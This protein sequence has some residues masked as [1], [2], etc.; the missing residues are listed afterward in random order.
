MLLKSIDIL[1]FKSF[2]DKTHLEFSRGIT[3]LLGPNGC[4][5]SNILDSVKWALGEQSSRS[6]RADK[7]EDVIFSGT[8]S[9]KALNLA[10]VTLI[11]SNEKEELPLDLTEISIKRRLYRS[12]ESEYFINNTPVRLREIREL[13]FDTGVG[14]SAYSIME[15]GK[16]DQILSSKPEDR[17]FIAEEA[18]GIT[19]YRI[20]EIEAERKLEKTKENMRQV[21]GIIGEV[22]RSW[23]LLKRQA[24]RT[25]NYRVL[26]EQV[27][28]LELE[29]QLLRLKDFLEQ[30]ESTEEKFLG[31]T[32]ERDALRQG[33]EAINKNMELDFDLVNS[34]ESRLIE[35]QKK[36]YKIDLEKHNNESQIKILRERS[37]ELERKI[38]SD[39]ERERG[40]R[41]KLARL[42]EELEGKKRELNELSA[43]LKDVQANIQG[44]ER[45]IKQFEARIHE[46]E[47]EILRL[48]RDTLS[49]EEEIE[50]RRI[51]LRRITDDI[52]T[53][54]DQ[55]LKDLGYST[56]SRKKI[57][58]EILSAVESI[59]IQISGRL[60]LLEDLSRVQE[61]SAKGDEKKILGTTLPVLQEV[62]A[63]I[64]TLGRL[65]TE[66]R[67]VT[68]SFLEEFLA[69]EGIITR[70]REIDRKISA[71]LD[72]INRKRSRT[73]ELQQESRALNAKIIEYRQTLEGLR[74]NRARMNTQK[75]GLDNEVKRLGAEISEQD[76]FLK[77]NA[78]EI[79]LSRQSLKEIAMRIG[80]LTKEKG[81]LEE[82]NR[83]LKRDLSS[84]EDKIA[85]KNKTLISREQQLKG[86][87]AKLEKLQSGLER[88][89]MDLAEC[90]AEIRNLYQN[91]SD[92]HSRDLSEFESRTLRI[93][94]TLKELRAGLLGRKDELKKLGQVNLMAVE[95]FAEVNDRYTF[96]SGQLNDLRKASEDLQKITRE[97]R[98]ESAELFLE[99]Y[100][101][102][103]KNF[104]LM[105]RRL[106][107]GGRAELKLTDPANVLES[108][109]EIFAQPPGK[110]LENIALL[111]GGEKSLTAIGLLFATYMVKPSPFCIL[112]EID[113]ALDEANIV[114]FIQLLREFSTGSQFIVITHNK[115]T[116]AGADTMLGITMEESGVSKIVALRL[117]NK[118]E[119]KSS[120]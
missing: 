43:L 100:N 78:A 44:F 4:G 33:I 12:G 10:E 112:D 48:R 76:I 28:E 32:L 115:K 113:A 47:S 111:S 9:R 62:L 114:R 80:Q 60:K 99:A 119:E 7:M 25:R 58:E 59:R 30:K 83:E 2:A 85:R 6:L 71:I 84:L 69:P 107:G 31:K 8:E 117:E 90:K 46:N 106:F 120:A 57:E 104:H 98:N 110:K 29:I 88:L 21:G 5:K 61:E 109:I 3:S 26:T 34:M 105:F 82:E 87:T 68:P 18:A 35:N 93:D 79:E 72:G 65:F 108:G 89:Q 73:E 55:R 77:A 23:E 81:V 11:L 95:E 51:D 54:L 86:K 36:L 15:Q 41:A 16:I 64:E 74:V 37:S 92:Q 27:F 38:A 40:I 103:N 70:K 52:V 56:Q 66:Y 97:I 102:I 49:L 101:R 39:E 19:K 20:R 50:A 17:R 116:V 1:G 45:D 118:V 94:K 67:R 63:R 96:L 14:K 22:R 13:F 91:F 42:K 24:E 75:I 53:Q